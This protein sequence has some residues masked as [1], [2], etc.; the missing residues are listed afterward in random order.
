[1]LSKLKTMM[2]KLFVRQANEKPTLWE[3]ILEEFPPE[4][5]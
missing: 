4:L 1:M 2:L 5:L 3:E